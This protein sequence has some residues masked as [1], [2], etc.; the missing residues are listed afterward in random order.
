MLS[1]S[2]TA[3]MILR[4]PQ[5]IDSEELAEYIRARTGLYVSAGINMGKAGRDFCVSISH[6][7]GRW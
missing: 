1:D 5:N 7:P 3:M 4:N 2:Q 6:V